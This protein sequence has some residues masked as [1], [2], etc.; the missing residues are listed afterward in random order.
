LIL[1]EGDK[2]RKKISLSYFIAILLLTGCGGSNNNNSKNP[3]QKNK[4]PIVDAGE[5]KT[6]MVNEAITIKGSA[7]DT[8]GTVVSYEWRKGDEVL[9]T[10]ATLN[11]IP[12][13]VGIETLTLVAIDDD[14]DSGKD[15]INITVIDEN[16]D[17]PSTTNLPTVSKKSLSQ[18]NTMQEADIIKGSV[19]NLS[20]A[21]YKDRNSK[22]WYISPVS[23]NNKVDVYS[24]MGFK[25]EKNG[26]ATVGKNV[27]SFDLYNETITIDYINDN[28]DYRYYDVGWREYNTD[29]QIQK[30]IEYIRNSTVDIKWWFFHASTGSWYIINK[31]GTT[32]RFSSKI[33]NGQ[34]VYDW[35]KIDMGGERPNFFV[36]DGAKKLRFPYKG[37]I[38]TYYDS[39]SRTIYVL[40]SNNISNPR[41]YLAGKN[42][43]TGNCLGDNAEVHMMELKPLENVNS[44]IRANLETEARV[45]GIDIKLGVEGSS[46]SSYQLPSVY[47]YDFDSLLI[48]EL[49]Y[50]VI[51]TEAG[52]IYSSGW[53]PDDGGGCIYIPNPL[54]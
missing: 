28:Y 30:D 12:T 5:D 40:A 54:K 27:A 29:P 23:S 15:S 37:I 38:S 50:N 7:T 20:W 13:R 43:I 9:G 31:S 16:N 44:N 52:K 17:L 48:G 45:K 46:S 19:Q 3:D 26:W 51:A 11:Y 36:E 42:R 41:V 25:G 6:V 10:E 39:S 14:G 35:I 22:R 32:Y 33:E 4:P 47:Y 34:R 2:M 24:L 49:H 8:D 18:K 21:Y 53:L 1:W